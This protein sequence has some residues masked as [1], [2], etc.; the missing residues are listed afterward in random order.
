M[1]LSVLLPLVVGGILGIA[2]VLHLAGLSAPR[3]LSGPEDAAAAWMRHF[4]G[5]RL[6]AVAM[7]PDRLAARIE[8]DRGPGLVRC[9]GADTVAHRVTGVVRQ[10]AVLRIAFGDFG[11]PPARLVLSAEMAADWERHLGREGWADQAIPTS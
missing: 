6:R 11:A 3:R 7:T 2:L 10:G 1:P 9:L 5:D 4:P 8:T